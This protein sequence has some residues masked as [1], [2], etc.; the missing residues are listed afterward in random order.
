MDD[1]LANNLELLS[2]CLDRAESYDLQLAIETIPT[3]VRDPLSNIQQ[4]VADDQRSQVAL[5]TEFLARHQQIKEVFEA[6][7]LWKEQRV[8][9]V[10][11][12]DFNGRSL[13][14]NGKRQYLHPGEGSIDFISFFAGLRQHSFSGTV[15]LEAPAINAERQVDIDKLQASLNFIK[16]GLAQNI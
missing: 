8:R 11:I 16:Q 6:D 9:H 4:A 10:H 7:W 1:N 2:T 5:D 3:R 13:S 15:S 14:S 12:K